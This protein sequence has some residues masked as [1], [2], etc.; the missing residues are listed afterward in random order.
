MLGRDRVRAGRTSRTDELRARPG[1]SISDGLAADS[2]RAV[3]LH[4][5]D[6]YF[7]FVFDE[8]IAAPRAASRNDPSIVVN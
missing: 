1:G 6:N 8:T 2:S 5:Y 7:L 3:A 4:L